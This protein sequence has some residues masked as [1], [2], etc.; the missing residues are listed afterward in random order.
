VLDVNL[1][2]SFLHYDAY[3]HLFLLSRG[4]SGDLERSEV[5]LDWLAFLLY[6][7]GE[8]EELKNLLFDAVVLLAQ[9]IC[10]R[11][12]CISNILFINDGRLHFRAPLSGCLQT[13]LSGR[14]NTVSDPRHL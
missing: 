4:L 6:L 9:F 8:L 3:S 14:V 1:P 2:C 11:F 13:M 7:C 12:E 5:G 10:Q